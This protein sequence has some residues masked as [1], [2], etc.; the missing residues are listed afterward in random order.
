MNLL[1]SYLMIHFSRDFSKTAF[2]VLPDNI[3]ADLPTLQE[4]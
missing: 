1:F 4:L 2:T 3:F